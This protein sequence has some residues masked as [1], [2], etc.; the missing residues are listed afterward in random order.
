MQHPPIKISYRGFGKPLILKY[1]L[2]KFIIGKMHSTIYDPIYCRIPWRDFIVCIFIILCT[3]R[4]SEKDFTINFFH[5]SFCM[6][7]SFYTL[8]LHHNL[9][10]ICISPTSSTILQYSKDNNIWEIRTFVNK[11]KISHSSSIIY[12]MLTLHDLLPPRN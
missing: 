9:F 11:G 4:P 10:Q 5:V 12:Y 8:D 2:I 6:F 7:I 3:W 1:K